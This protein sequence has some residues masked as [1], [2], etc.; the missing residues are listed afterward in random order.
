M[1]IHECCKK[2]RDYSSRNGH[3]QKMYKKIPKR[4]NREGEK[5]G[6]GQSAV[7]SLQSA[8]RCE[9]KNGKHTGKKNTM[10]SNKSA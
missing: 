8:R 9:R 2:G 1:L 3:E 10:M 7:G 4:H 6:G 5:R